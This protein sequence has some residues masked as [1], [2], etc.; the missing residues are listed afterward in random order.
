[1]ACSSHVWQAGNPPYGPLGA[2]GLPYAAL[3]ETVSLPYGALCRPMGDCAYG[4]L[5]RVACPSALGR[6]ACP[7]SPYGETVPALWVILAYG[8]PYAALWMA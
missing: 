2:C 1:M 5:G 3:W 7:M 4:P 8:L 6:M